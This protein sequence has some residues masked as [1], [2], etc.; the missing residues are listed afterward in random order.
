[1]KNAPTVSS[2]PIG[3]INVDVRLYV[4]YK[5][6]QIKYSTAYIQ[7]YKEKCS[8]VLATREYTLY[9]NFAIYSLTIYNLTIYNLTIYRSKSSLQP[10]YT[11]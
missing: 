2:R 9:T 8:F 10:N 4:S 6:F 1:M 7:N 11:Q 5:L 3:E